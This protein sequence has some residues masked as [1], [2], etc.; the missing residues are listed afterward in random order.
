M[1]ELRECVMMRFSRKSG[2]I[3]TTMEGLGCGLMKMWALNNTTSTKDTVIFDKEDGTIYGYYEGKK[4]DMP[5]IC[6]DLEG[7]N[8]EE[9]CEGILS[10]I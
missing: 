8:I 4:N 5:T 7:R 9:L 6:R 1:K 10:Q 3:D 2:K